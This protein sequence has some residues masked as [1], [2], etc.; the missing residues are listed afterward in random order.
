VRNTPAPDV[1]R[2]LRELGRSHDPVLRA[3]AR[4]PTVRLVQLFLTDRLEDVPAEDEAV[5]RWAREQALVQS[6]ENEGRLTLTLRGE[7]FLRV[8]R[9]VRRQFG[10]EGSPG[11]APTA[12]APPPAPAEPSGRTVR[13]AHG[14]VRRSSS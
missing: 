14:A 3:S 9:Y 1:P 12:P 2:L 4:D 11:G 13:S 8:V 7:H 5:L 10:P 6:D